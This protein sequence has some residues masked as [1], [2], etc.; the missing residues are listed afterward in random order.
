M[1]TITNTLGPPGNGGTVNVGAREDLEDMI[2]R[3]APEE[4]PLI[5]NIGSV[6]ASA[7]K[8][9]WQTE[10][11]AAASS[12]NAHLEGDDLGTTYSAPNVPSRVSNICQ[13][14]EKDGLVSR[15]QQV[16]DLAGRANELDRQK[17]LKGKELKRD[18]EFRMMVNGASVLETGATARTAGGLLA[19]ATSNVSRGVG[20]SS[21]SFSGGVVAA[22]T[23]GTQRTFTEAL[24]KTVLA[25]TFNNGGRVT[26]GY[27]A[28]AH[29]QLFSAFTGIADIRTSVSG[30]DQATIY[31]GADVYVSD[32]SPIT[33]IPHAYALT[34]DCAFIDPKMCAVA[35]LD[36]M[37]SFDMA[38][39]GDAD[40]FMIT[41]EKTL[42]VRNE[43]AIAVVADLT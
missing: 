24:V 1:T 5:N 9:E 13:I 20:G 22:A 31:G 18:V 28:A 26:Q 11:L 14:F 7:I 8:H 38:K 39:T 33:L 6:K 10:S 19:W 41:T 3:V 42:V 12:T 34:R 35:T 29:K 30:T 16:L 17:I 21:G 2:Y 15:T 37:K 32:F 25:T 43:K 27:M 36:G 23:N 4:T 40:K